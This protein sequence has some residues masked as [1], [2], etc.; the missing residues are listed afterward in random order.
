MTWMRMTINKLMCLK[1][2]KIVIC[3]QQPLSSYWAKLEE[4]L[5]CAGLG[6]TCEL[7]V[8]EIV[9]INIMIYDNVKK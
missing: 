8:K 7:Y 2:S 9:K 1:E 6:L 4:I 3:Q 5:E